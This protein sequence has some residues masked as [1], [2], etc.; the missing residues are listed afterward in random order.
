MATKIYSKEASDQ[1]A[2]R[3]HPD[4]LQRLKWRLQP[5]LPLLLAQGPSLA[6]LLPV[7]LHIS[8]TPGALAQVHVVGD[9]P[10]NSIAFL[11]RHPFSA[12]ACNGVPDIHGPFFE[13]FKI[14][15]DADNPLH[16]RG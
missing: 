2:V 10:E 11:R 7:D 4:Q 5:P 12:V 1:S 15:R 14:I 9:E 16:T 3:M 8:Y 6:G 13:A